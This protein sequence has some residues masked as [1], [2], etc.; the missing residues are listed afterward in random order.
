[1]PATDEGDD[2]GGS[3]RELLTEQAKVVLVV[4][5]T[6]TLILVITYAVVLVL[7]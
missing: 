3:G 6:V 7:L 5:G 4:W 2:P 1:M